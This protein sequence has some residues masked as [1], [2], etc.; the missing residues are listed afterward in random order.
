MNLRSMVLA[1]TVCAPSWLAAQQP[2]LPLAPLEVKG[3]RLG[4]DRQAVEAAVGPIGCTSDVFKDSVLP[5]EKIKELG[6]DKP[7]EEETCGEPRR[8]LLG[9]QSK[10][11]LLTFAGWGATFGLTFKGGQLVRVSVKG[12]PNN[13]EST[14][15]LLVEKFGAPTSQSSTVVKN[16]MNAEFLDKTV[17]WETDAELMTFSKYAGSTDASYLV[18]TSR[19][20]LESE[21]QRDAER[22][23]KDL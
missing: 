6:L 15:K 8:S 3:M 4:M 9:P 19:T 21:R 18:L 20:Y 5:P 11:E 13:F 1:L 12:H 10:T 17:S 2:G 14:R 16:R 23:S 7:L 22:A